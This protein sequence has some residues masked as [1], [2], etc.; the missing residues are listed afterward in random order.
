M[1]SNDIR[2]TY[3]D[4][5]EGHGHAVFPSS[6]L[7]P[8]GDPTVLFTTAGMQQ[9]K[10]YFSGEKAA[11]HPRIA[12][13]QKCVRTSDIESVGDD[14]HLTF[15]EMLG[16]FAFDDYFK[17]QSIEFAWELLIDRLGLER[18]RMWATCFGGEGI[19]PRDTD[20]FEIWQEVGVPAERIRFFGRA[21]NFWGPTGGSGACG[22]DTEIHYELRPAAPGH[23][24]SGPN[25]ECERFLELWNLVFNEFFQDIGGKLTPLESVGVDTGAGLERW[26][27]LLQDKPNIYETDLF[28]VIRSSAA[29]A[30]GGASDASNGGERPL[31]I[32]AEHS[33]SAVFMLADG[34][35]PGNEGRGYVL[36]RLI[37]RAVGQ[38]RLAGRLEPFLGGVAE[39]TIEVMGRFYPEVVDRRHHILTVVEEE[40][41]R[42][43][44]TLDRGLSLVQAKITELG[45]STIIDGKSAFLFHDT[46]GVPLDLVKDVAGSAGLS[47]D[48]AGFAVAMERQRE[49]SR[50]GT[51]GVEST[52]PNGLPPSQ[53]IGYGGMTSG[54]GE[55]VAILSGGEQVSS[56]D[57]GAEGLLVISETPF[58]SEAGGQVGDTGT[59]SG[60]DFEFRVTD[61]Q[62][63]AEG[64]TFHIGTV[65]T[66]SGRSG[67][68]VACA[69]DATRRMD[70]ARNHTATHLV[71][72]ALREVLGEQVRQS[73]S[74]VAADHLRFDFNHGDSLSP[75]EIAAVERRVNRNV[76][77][78]I[79]VSTEEREVREAV[80][81]GALALFG[82]AYGDIV[83]V[84]TINEVSVEL[85]GGT[86]LRD[87]AG[88]GSFAIIREE[89]VG[90]GLRRV[91]A[92]TG[93][94]AVD[95]SRAR[96]ESIRE[97][98]AALNAP[99]EDVTERVRRLL[100][101]NSEHRREL[102]RLRQ[103]IANQQVDAVVA[104]SEILSGFSV[105]TEQIDVDDS[106]TLRVLSDSLRFKL[107]DDWA[108]LIGAVVDGR[109]LFFAA[110]SESAVGAG[111][112][113]GKI[114]ETAAKTTGGGG[115]G[116]PEMANGGGRD[117]SRLMDGLKAGRQ[118]LLKSL[119]A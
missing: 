114:V 103:R 4:F 66:G 57:E 78:A 45:D 85:C 14:S 7:V 104:K 35:L 110:A 79:Q 105:V 56:I 33:R 17:R 25:C 84:V 34:V 106:S 46:Y 95:S 3:L 113:A 100:E 12:T 42:F 92:V 75:E 21:D 11:P 49:L 54:D 97:T 108:F 115:G 30:L 10:P 87:T 22:P 80:E 47:V 36:R 44:R 20:S 77:A 71:H 69:V 59:I 98:A 65:V 9:F 62:R 86:H 68:P 53:F 51:S 91:V 58:Y 8:V 93:R 24:C 89:S 117:A 81:G 55:I 109:P 94:A 39:A 16:N 23:D 73:G 50:A 19:V 119:G 29:D 90:S 18:G 61:T 6:S 15:F 96:M 41:E 76:L 2:K 5:F 67:D 83:R 70:V 38:A 82:E 13:A 27:V 74:L 99:I 1:N 48:E 63:N 64:T 43:S 112:N 60:G 28:A 72:A 101:E 102:D 107:G 111:A 26:A 52:L 118:A 37:R 40:E 32:I 88:I 31:R 116:R